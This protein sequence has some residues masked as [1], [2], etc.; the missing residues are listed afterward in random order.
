MIEPL[1]L[2]SWWLIRLEE[3]AAAIVV[4]VE[5]RIEDDVRGQLR[6]NA[7]ALKL[8]SEHL[9]KAG[10]L[11][12]LTKQVDEAIR[13]LA[14]AQQRYRGELSPIVD[15]TPSTLFGRPAHGASVA[16]SREAQAWETKAT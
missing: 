11:D 16:A 3:A 12:A 5:A 8:A 10:A 1:A 6:Q 13:M 4:A 14:A 15:A 7:T 2:A 9:R